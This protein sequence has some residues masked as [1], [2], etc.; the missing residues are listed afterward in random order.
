MVV[1]FG[2]CVESLG[3]RKRQAS[4]GSMPFT[5]RRTCL[6]GLTR[7]RRA[8]DAKQTKSAQVAVTK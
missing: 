3:G 4:A 7:A 5:V 6:Q 8:H 1:D 2:Q